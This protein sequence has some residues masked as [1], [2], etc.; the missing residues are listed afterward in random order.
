MVQAVSERFSAIFSRLVKTNSRSSVRLD[1][2]GLQVKASADGT[3]MTSFAVVL[4]DLAALTLAMEG[5]SQHPDF[6]LHDSP[7][8]A[9]L[10]RSL[11]AELFNFAHSLEEVGS[12]PPFQYIITTTSEPPERYRSSPWL[13][14]QLQG[15]PEDERLFRVNL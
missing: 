6:L 13:R 2:N 1:G 4:F 7:R 12:A 5:K 10:G 11:Y 15:S 9:D 14:L 3:A 8:E